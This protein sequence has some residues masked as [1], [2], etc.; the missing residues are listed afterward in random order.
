MINPNKL[1]NE[2]LPVIEQTLHWRDCALY[3]LALGVGLDPMDDG[4][5]R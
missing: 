5:L 2:A 1:L 4:D 3:A